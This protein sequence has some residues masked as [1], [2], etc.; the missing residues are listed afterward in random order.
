ME[1]ATAAEYKPADHDLIV[2]RDN[3]T[4]PYGTDSNRMSPTSEEAIINRLGECVTLVSKIQHGRMFA[5]GFY[6]TFWMTRRLIE[7]KLKSAYDKYIE[8][9]S[10]DNQPTLDE[11][12][13]LFN[14]YQTWNKILREHTVNFIIK[15]VGLIHEEGGEASSAVREGNRKDD[16][17]TDQ[18]GI[19]CELADVLIRA[20][21]LAGF[22]GIDLGAILVAK[23]GY[24]A[25]RP[26]MHGKDA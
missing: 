1:T 7:D 14:E 22:M 25:T 13:L 20:F 2:D 8:S 3:G 11:S 6:D 4:N 24:N 23:I 16:K 26:R 12:N 19:G 9:T 21:D 5:K 15:Q 10:G 17:L 18:S